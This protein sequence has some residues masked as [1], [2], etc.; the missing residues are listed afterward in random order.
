V[1]QH[2]CQTCCVLLETRLDAGSIVKIHPTLPGR[3]NPN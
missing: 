1:S 2:R 3:L